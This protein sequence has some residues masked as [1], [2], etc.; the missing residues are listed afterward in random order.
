MRNKPARVSA[1]SPPPSPRQA[2]VVSAL[3][4]RLH[5]AAIGRAGAQRADHT[6]IDR[7]RPMGRGDMKSLMQ[8]EGTQIVAV[9]D[10]FEDRREA[11]KNVANGAATETEPARRITTSGRCSPARIPTR[12]LH[13]GAGSLVRIDCHGGSLSGQ[14]YLLPEAAGHH[15]RGELR[16]ATPCAATAACFRPHPAAV[17]TA[18][19]SRASWARNGYL[20][21]I[22]TIEVASPGPS[23][24]RRYTKPTTPEPILPGFD[25][26]MYQGPPPC[27]TTAASGRGPTGT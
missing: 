20:G 15:R 12:G 4:R 18:P 1:A 27:H 9:C 6:R 13:H 19:A 17:R 3:C 22:H 21:K 14:G 10:V 2:L 25:F 24:Q 23:Y 11:A 7:R 5:S 16:S 8:V 26:D